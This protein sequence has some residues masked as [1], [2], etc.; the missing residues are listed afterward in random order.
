VDLTYSVGGG[1]A[2][3]ITL[4]MAPEGITLGALGMATLSVRQRRSRLA[5]PWM[6][7]S[8]GCRPSITSLAFRALQVRSGR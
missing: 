8:A 7:R 3:N 6:I 2:S 4:Y 1:S 5:M